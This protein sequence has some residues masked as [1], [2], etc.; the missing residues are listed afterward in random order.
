M[1][2]SELSQ[3]RRQARHVMSQLLQHGG[4]LRPYVVLEHPDRMSFYVHFFDDAKI[5]SDDNTEGYES[6]MLGELI[7]L[8]HTTQPG[9]VVLVC[10]G[11]FLRNKGHHPGVMVIESAGHWWAQPEISWLGPSGIGAAEPYRGITCLLR[12]IAPPRNLYA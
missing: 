6:S 11:M 9:R 8:T 10:P 3:A 7:E 5:G 12:P 2:R 1:A 4:V